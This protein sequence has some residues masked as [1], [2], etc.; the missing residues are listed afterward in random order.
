MIELYNNQSWSSDL[1]AF[2]IWFEADS[3]RQTVR[4]NSA[5]KV[6][7]LIGFVPADKFITQAMIHMR[8]TNP[9]VCIRSECVPRTDQV[10][11]TTWV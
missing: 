2:L 4:H 6:H 10:Q 11:G 1:Q 7:K 3:I 5:R 8:I 9:E